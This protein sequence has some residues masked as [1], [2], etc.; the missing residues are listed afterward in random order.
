VYPR[1]D[2][3]T[4]RFGA[5]GDLQ[6]TFFSPFGVL[7]HGAASV[8]SSLWVDAWVAAIWAPGGLSLGGG[9]GTM[10]VSVFEATFGAPTPEGT[11]REE[12]V[13]SLQYAH[14]TAA[15]RS[16]HHARWDLGVS[17]GASAPVLRYEVGAG[18]L[19]PPIGGERYR[20]GLGVDGRRGTL[21][22]IGPGQREVV[23]GG[24]QIVI[25]LDWVRGEY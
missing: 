23:V 8:Q 3:R 25:R 18:L 14:G 12:R 19:F 4:L 6:L 17:V 13:R 24:N 10:S 7:A 5:A 15:L 22:E 16:R 11:E 20:I 21:V 9:V 2:D 1:V